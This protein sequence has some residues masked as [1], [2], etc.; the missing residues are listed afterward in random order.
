MRLFCLTAV[1]RFATAMYW[2]I[3][4]VQLRTRLAYAAALIAIPTK[5]TQ[6]PGSRKVPSQTVTLTIRP[7][8]SLR[9]RM[10]PEALLTPPAF[11]E[12]DD[13]D[14]ALGERDNGSATSTSLASIAVKYDSRHGRRYHGY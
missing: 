2:L 9:A 12:V 1:L 5:A 11:V 13:T 3:F 7:L 6:N 4:M 14:S 8:A 10:C